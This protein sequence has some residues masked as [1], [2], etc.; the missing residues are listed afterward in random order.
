MIIIVGRLAH[1]LHNGAATTPEGAA[2]I[3]TTVAGPLGNV[4]LLANGHAGAAGGNEE[5]D[6]KDKC[7]QLTNLVN[8]GGGHHVLVEVLLV[9]VVS[10]GIWILRNERNNGGL[11]HPIQGNEQHEDAHYRLESGGDLLNGTWVTRPSQL[12]SR[13]DLSQGNFGKCKK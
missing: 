10:L 3:L 6:S 7:N 8:N 2:A 5:V 13:H 12:H 1:H 9:D 11:H 4:V